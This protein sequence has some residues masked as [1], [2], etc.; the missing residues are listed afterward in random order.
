MHVNR[1]KAVIVQI[2]MPDILITFI[3][4]K[5]LLC[6][7]INA[8]PAYQAFSWRLLI[9]QSSHS[10]LA[11]MVSSYKLA[12]GISQ[13]ARCNNHTNAVYQSKAIFNRDVFLIFCCLSCRNHH[14]ECSQRAQEIQAVPKK[15]SITENILIMTLT[16]SASWVKN[17]L[18]YNINANFYQYY[19]TKYYSDISNVKFVKH[20]DKIDNK[21]L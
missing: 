15:C 4:S 11:C 1:I 16:A 9:W 6:Y 14:L 5:E 7:W 12:P 20:Q 19:D 8:A 10:H 13:L 3:K 21:L 17:V 2:N 18:N